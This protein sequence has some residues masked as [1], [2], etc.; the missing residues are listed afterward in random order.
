MSEIL[1][2]L[3]LGSD[4]QKIYKT[5]LVSGQLTAGEIRAITKLTSSMVDSTLGKLVEQGLVRSVPGMSERYAALLPVK[6]VKEGLDQSI[7]ELSTVTRELDESSKSTSSALDQINQESLQKLDASLESSRGVISEMYENAT[8]ELTDEKTKTESQITQTSESRQQVVKQYLGETQGQVN[9]LIDSTVEKAEDQT[10]TA[11]EAVNRTATELVDTTILPDREFEVNT[12]PLDSFPTTVTTEM[13]AYRTDIEGSLSSQQDKSA[14]LINQT[15]ASYEAGIADLEKSMDTTS[16]SFINASTG[17]GNRVGEQVAEIK[18]SIVSQKEAL[19]LQ[20]GA[21]EGVIDSQKS[22]TEE[23]GQK[24][25]DLIDKGTQDLQANVN[26]EY[27][28]LN[29]EVTGLRSETQQSVTSTSTELNQTENKL[30]EFFVGQLQRQEAE[31]KESLQTHFQQILSQLQSKVSDVHTAFSAQMTEEL[32]TLKA[33]REATLKASLERSNGRLNQVEEQFKAVQNQQISDLYAANEQLKN[34]LN[35]MKDQLGSKSE[36]LLSSNTAVFERVNTQ[37]SKQGESWDVLKS[38]FDSSLNQVVE[39]QKRLVAEAKTQLAEDKQTISQ[40]ISSL[41]ESHTSLTATNIT[42]VNELTSRIL[43]NITEK[44]QGL[45]SEVLSSSEKFNQEYKTAMNSLLQSFRGSVQK[46]MEQYS[47]LVTSI[48]SESKLTLETQKSKMTEMMQKMNE[49]ME[50]LFLNSLGVQN[51]LVENS[52]SFLTLQSNEL[53][54]LSVSNLD[55]IKQVLSQA[56]N[57]QVDKLKGQLNSFQ[58]AFD[59]SSHRIT[60]ASTQLSMALEGVGSLIQMTETPTIKTSHLIGKEAIIEHISDMIGRVK[61]K[62][63][64]LV[65]DINMINENQ[66][67]QLPS[68]KQITLVSYIDEETDREWIDRMHNL[69]VNVTLRTL[70]KGGLGGTVPDFVGAEREGEEILL[71]TIDEGNNDFVAI[72]SSSAYFV[73]ILG[74]IVIS[75]YAR[76]RSK[77]LQKN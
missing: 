45:K 19:S 52:I 14:E 6:K 17:F 15:F 10:T 57:E 47:N 35:T 65:P 54:T 4:E 70:Q 28:K 72:I 44:T 66:L 71:G 16:A 8:K 18:S 51:K 31:I 77:Q 24:F 74:N 9:S 73:Q 75:D 29:E 23:I 33:F 64:I 46:A 69:T 22:F 48:G 5:L 12:T 2:S 26:A 37:L 38:N 56:G 59:Q 20:K 39:E 76:G 3:G 61:S 67:S 25:S 63:T 32:Q 36:E 49:D 1:A 34:V 62:M 13:N 27:L 40:L 55:L 43:S 11:K 60:Q 41:G 30:S 21:S 58:Q 50:Q 68:T 42:Q 53:K 7:M